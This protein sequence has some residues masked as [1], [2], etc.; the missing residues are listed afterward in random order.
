MD[1]LTVKEV[2]RIAGVTKTA[3]IQ[4]ERLGKIDAVRVGV[5]HGP[6]GGRMRLFERSE[7]LRFLARR[8]LA[9][10]KARRSRPKRSTERRDG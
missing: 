2:C 8:S 6:Y 1:K 4:W 10:E 5:D 3:V 7:V 9:R